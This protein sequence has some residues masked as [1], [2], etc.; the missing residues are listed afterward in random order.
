VYAGYC[1]G[2]KIAALATI[3]GEV[4]ARTIA[5]YLEK[6]NLSAGTKRYVGGFSVGK[7][8]KVDSDDVLYAILREEG[9]IKQTNQSL[10]AITGELVKILASRNK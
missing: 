10:D 8:K 5:R 2:Y 6:Y 1:G 4:P 7:I 9:S 3:R